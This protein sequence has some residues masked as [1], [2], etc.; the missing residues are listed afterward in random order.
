MILKQYRS[1]VMP[2]RMTN[3]HFRIDTNFKTPI[4]KP[5]LIKEEVTV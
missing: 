4:R 1:F 2:A 3:E 5:E